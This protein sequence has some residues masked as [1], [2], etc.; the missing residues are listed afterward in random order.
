M[1]LGLR[2]SS[3]AIVL[4]NAYKDT[5]VI[6]EATKLY[7]NIIANEKLKNGG[8]ADHFA[9]AGAN[10][11]IWNSYKNYVKVHQMFF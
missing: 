5:K 1:G 2:E 10:D 11:R 6:D 4:R 7:E 9:A 8:G 3:G